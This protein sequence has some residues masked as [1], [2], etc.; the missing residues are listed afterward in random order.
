MGK[1]PFILIY[2]LTIF[3]VPGI[4]VPAKAQ[5]TPDDVCYFSVESFR[6]PFAKGDYRVLEPFTLN[7]RERMATQ[8][9]RT[10][11]K[12]II[13]YEVSGCTHLFETVRF[14]YNEKLPIEYL[15]TEGLEYI[16]QLVRDAP[17]TKAV[18]NRL[19][20]RVQFMQDNRKNSEY[21]ACEDC[22]PDH[23]KI[24]LINDLGETISLTLD[25]D[26]FTIVSDF[27]L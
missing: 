3:M 16:E 21:F 12:T 22:A 27:P 24:I 15:F 11:D 1:R 10:S 18:K 17:L 13:Y 26:T 6:E 19:L 25:G 7:K 14:R 4:S 5:Q 20:V 9:I 23:K 2:A 8:K